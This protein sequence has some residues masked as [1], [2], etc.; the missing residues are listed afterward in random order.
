M[1][2]HIRVDHSNLNSE[3]KFACGTGPALPEGDKWVYESES[4]AD[5][6]DCPG[7]NP[8]GPVPLGVSARELDGNAAARHNKP[9]AWERW[10]AFCEANGHP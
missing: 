10:V 7:C 2:L 6:A 1:T 4:M 3:R 9:E 8:A 5:R